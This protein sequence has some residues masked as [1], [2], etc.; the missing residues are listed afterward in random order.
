MGMGMAEISNEVYLRV[1]QE[2]GPPLKKSGVHEINKAFFDIMLQALNAGED[3]S[4]P[5]FGKFKIIE[6]AER[7]GR[8][9][10]TGESMRITAKKAVRFR[11]ANI[12]RMT[13]AGI[14]PEAKKAKPAKVEGKKGSAKEKAVAKEKGKKI[15]KK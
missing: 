6:R 13:I 4:I 12:L 10:K 14:D 5:K 11:P 8:N 1:D 15:S 3:I 9:P 7:N 2:G